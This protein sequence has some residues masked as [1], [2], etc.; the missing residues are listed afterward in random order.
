MLRLTLP[1]IYGLAGI[2]I[3]LITFSFF[4]FRAMRPGSTQRDIDVFWISIIIFLAALAVYIGFFVSPFLAI[5]PLVPIYIFTRLF[6]STR[7][8]SKK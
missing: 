6:L 8:S 4:G 7:K 3:L 5:A 1:Q 2:F